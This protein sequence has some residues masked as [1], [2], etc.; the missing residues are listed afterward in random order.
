MEKLALDSAQNK[1]MVNSAAC[2]VCFSLM[3][4]DFDALADTLGDLFALKGDPV[5]EANIRAA[6][7]GYDQAERE[8]KGVCPYCALHQKV[9]QAKGRM[10][11]T[12]SEAAGYGSLISGL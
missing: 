4:Y 10:L 6:R 7:A 12:G 2:G 8:F 1:L 5:V 11:M 9:Q 3:E